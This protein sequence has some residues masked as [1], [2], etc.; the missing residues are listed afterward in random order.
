MD[1]TNIGGPPC[2]SG[3]ASY[4]AGTGAAE[5]LPDR[6]ARGVGRMESPRRPASEPRPT[7]PT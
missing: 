2:E 5:A 4:Q 7:L 1:F 3:Q 6:A